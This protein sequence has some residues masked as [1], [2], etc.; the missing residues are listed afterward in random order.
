MTTKVRLAADG[1]VAV[2]ASPARAIDFDDL[3]E[4]M[5]EGLKNTRE[6]LV[7]DNKREEM[8]GRW[9]T[10]K[11]DMCR[12]DRRFIVEIAKGGGGEWASRA[13]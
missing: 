2:G 6:R 1:G 11:V 10:V 7:S 13:G 12:Q 5:G 4:M 9:R 8:L 3:G